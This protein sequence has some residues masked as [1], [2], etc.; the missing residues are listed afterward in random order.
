MTSL[1]RGDVSD[2]INLKTGIRLDGM[3]N[4]VQNFMKKAAMAVVTT[5]M[6]WAMSWS[7]YNADLVEQPRSVVL[8]FII[9]CSIG[10]GLAAVLLALTS[11]RYSLDEELAEL[12]KEDK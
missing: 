11:R 7:G 10:A 2:L 4:N 8:F 6:G 5:V 3:V 1:N 12:R 9:A